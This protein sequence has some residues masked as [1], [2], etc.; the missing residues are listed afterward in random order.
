[1]YNKSNSHRLLRVLH[2]QGQP[3]LWWT[4][5]SD[6]F[7]N[8]WISSIYSQTK[9]QY[10]LF[11][12][13]GWTG[14]TQVRLASANQQKKVTLT[15]W[16]PPLTQSSSIVWETHFLLLLI[17]HR[18]AVFT[19]TDTHWYHFKVFNNWHNITLQSTNQ[20]GICFWICMY[21]IKFGMY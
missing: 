10:R 16:T 3:D 4:K 12:P 15:T 1:M 7:Y 21:A 20:D 19:L 13:F 5:I 8:K 6:I 9:Y 18:P 11:L 14:G 2:M 17:V